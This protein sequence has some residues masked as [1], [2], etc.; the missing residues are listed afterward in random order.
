MKHPCLVGIVGAGSTPDNMPFLIMEFVSKGDLY[1]ILHESN[2]KEKLPDDKIITWAT[3]IACGMQ[4]LHS[5]GI[6]HRDLKSLNILVNF[7][8]LF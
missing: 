7:F 6:I 4:Y 3:D 1:H 2:T 5:L 8:K